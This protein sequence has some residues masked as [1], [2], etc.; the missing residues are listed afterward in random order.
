M[1]FLFFCPQ[2]F[3]SKNVIY[4]Y[5]PL[6]GML[7][8]IRWICIF[9]QLKMSQALL[10]SLESLSWGSHTAVQK[11][12]GPGP[13]QT[14]EALKLLSCHW[15]FAFP[16][17]HGV[18]WGTGTRGAASTGIIFIWFLASSLKLT[19]AKAE[20]LFKSLQWDYPTRPADGSNLP[21]K[22]VSPVTWPLCLKPVSAG[23]ELVESQGQ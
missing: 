2:H 8:L 15:I 5:N 1:Y 11:L 19:V 21:W 4:W 3:H 16:A 12:L 17:A 14:Q 20:R 10:F 6:T 13:F 7:Q 23:S 22:K 9:S 18:R